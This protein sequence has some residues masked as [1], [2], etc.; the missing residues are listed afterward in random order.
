M[1]FLGSIRFSPVAV[2]LTTATLDVLKMS[3]T[4][5]VKESKDNKN[6]MKK[7]KCKMKGK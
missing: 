4:F 5:E 3:K 1:L 7:Y 6:N 2:A